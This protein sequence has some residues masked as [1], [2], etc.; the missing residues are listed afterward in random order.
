MVY[1]VDH[2]DYLT[3]YGLMRKG[4]ELPEALTRIPMVWAGWGVKPRSGET[5]FVSHRRRDA[6][7]VRG[8]RRRIPHGA[9]GRSLWP[10][11]HGQDYP[12]EEFRSIYS[13]VGFGGLH[14]D[15]SDKL[16]F[17]MA[18]M[19]PPGAPSRPSTS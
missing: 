8:H 12:R 5:A 15:A 10:M 4:V 2:G 18:Q 19:A 14:Y 9:Q 7:S 17:A 16:D 3:D 13:E 6:D 1:L 11:L